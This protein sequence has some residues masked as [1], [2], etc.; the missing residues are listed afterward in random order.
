MDFADVDSVWRRN[1]GNRLVQ[2][3]P[4]EVVAVNGTI[5]VI[6]WRRQRVGGQEI[7]SCLGVTLR[8]FYRY[9]SAKGPDGTRVNSLP[10]L[11]A[12]TSGFVTDAYSAD[13]FRRERTSWDEVPDNWRD[14][15]RF[16]ARG[17]FFVRGPE[18]LER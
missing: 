11:I 1:F 4:A 2:D 6:P 16:K 3:R 17:N 5:C 14:Q 12:T 13:A 8:Q 10:W 18:A 9:T 15:G 7:A